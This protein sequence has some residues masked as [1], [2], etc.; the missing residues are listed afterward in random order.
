MRITFYGAA[1]EVTGSC[2]LLNAAGLNILVDCGMFQGGPEQESKNFGPLA[3]NPKDIN[4]VVVTHA[5]LDHVGRLPLLIRGGFTGY[6]YATPATIELAELILE[7]TLQIMTYNNE[8]LGTPILFD[9]TDIAAVMT[10]FK[11]VDYH[12]PFVLPG[13]DGEVKI[14]FYDAGHI[15]GSVFAV[16]DAEGKRA[17]FSGDIGNVNVPILRETESLPGNIDVLVCESTYGDRLHETNEKR[18]EV[19]E[20]MVSDAISH[21]GVLMIPSFSLERTQELIYDLND[22][23]DRKK[24]LPRVPIFLDS[25]LAIGA[26]KVYR[27]YVNYYDEKAKKLVENGDDLFEFPGLTMCETKEESI[28]INQVPAPKMII[29]GAGM[30]TGG[31]IVHH[32]KRYL[33]DD[34]STLLIIGY[35]AAGT[36]GRRILEGESPVMIY[37]EQIPVRCHIDAIGA[38]SAHGDQKKLLDWIGGGNALPKKVCLNHG[39]PLAAEG[40]AERVKEE[41]DVDAAIASFGTSIE[42]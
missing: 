39:E 9:N 1:K 36:L 11:A 28:R 10:Q 7:D 3:F 13:K 8:K 14:E 32:A 33:S 6:F 23:I 17:V 37:G 42:V 31:R 15:F 24:E 4:A 2:S 38:L 30:M 20:R 40:L 16:I 35:Q 27:K 25:P 29:A 41:F 5:H 19:I 26:T 18:Q 22:L 34:K 12:E 21:G